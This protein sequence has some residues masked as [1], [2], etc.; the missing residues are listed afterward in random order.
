MLVSEAMGGPIDTCS[1]ESTLA[2]AARRMTVESHGALPV[3]LHDRLI[4]IIT[5]RDMVRAM[6]DRRN[7]ETTTVGEFMTP[8]P[9]SLEPDVEVADAALWM[10]A[11]G[12]RHLPVVT[13]GQVIGML[14]I[15]DIMWA[16]TGDDRGPYESSDHV[17][18]A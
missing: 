8:E 4:G 11:A 7:P 18:R 12:Y 3:T 17:R 14:S 1:T 10:L 13:D 6:A 15:K 2:E 16:L 9:D 5:E